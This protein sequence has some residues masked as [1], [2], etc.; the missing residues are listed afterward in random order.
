MSAD[1]AAALTRLDLF[2]GLTAEESQRIAELGRIEYWKEGAVLLEEGAFGPRMMVL[3]EGDAEIL[4]RDGNGVERVIGRV[5]A[6]EALGEMSLLLDLPRTATVR[7]LSALRVF[8]MDREAFL[9]R[10]RQS[11]PAV[12]K[13]GYELSRT[14]ARRLMALNECVTSLLSENEEIRRRFGEARQESFQLW[15]PA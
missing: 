1:I 13:L 4:R 8:A 15:D 6:G 10:I 11:D 9:D 3:L 5:G 2:Q 12:L 7:A 14:L